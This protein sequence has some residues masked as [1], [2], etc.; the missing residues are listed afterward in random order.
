MDPEQPQSIDLSGISPDKILGAQPKPLASEGL[1][2]A[3]AIMDRAEKLGGAFASPSLQLKT[4]RQVGTVKNSPSV[5]GGSMA[6]KIPAFGKPLVKEA[7]MSTPK[8]KTAVANL[9][10]E[11]VARAQRVILSRRQTREQA[12]QMFDSAGES[13]KREQGMMGKLFVQTPGAETMAPALVKAA[14]I[15]PNT[16]AFFEKFASDSKLTVAQRRFPEL[17]DVKR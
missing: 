16:D 15:A 7:L 2:K 10:E 13:R 6:S 5:K 12:D 17:L 14:N 8:I 11:E 3:L 1:A 9:G 4:T